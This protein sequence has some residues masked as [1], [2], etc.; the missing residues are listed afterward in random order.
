MAQ[1]RVRPVYQLEDLAADF[2]VQLSE[3]TNR[4]VHR[5]IGNPGEHHKYPR[6][7]CA[8]TFASGFFV[9]LLFVYLRCCKQ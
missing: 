9:V 3:V 5:R 1:V 7:I 8:K 4:P 6:E 2:G